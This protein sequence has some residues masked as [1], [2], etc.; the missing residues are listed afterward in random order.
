MAASKKGW[1]AVITVLIGW[2]LLTYIAGDRQPG[3]SVDTAGFNTVTQA[4]AKAGVRDCLPRIDQVTNFIN[5]QSR[6]GACKGLYWDAL[7]I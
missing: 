2:G 3:V 4:I 1:I 6:S 7:N 5:T